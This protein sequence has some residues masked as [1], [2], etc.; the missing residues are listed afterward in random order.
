MVLLHAIGKRLWDLTFLAKSPDPLAT[1]VS[2]LRQRGRPQAPHWDCPQK[3][4]MSG[5]AG[6]ESYSGH[7]LWQL[8]PA[9][10]QPILEPKAS[11]LSR[12][13]RSQPLRHRIQNTEEWQAGTAAAVASLGGTG[14]AP[15][16]PAQA[17]M[18]LGKLVSNSD[19]FN[20]SL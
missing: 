15:G 18:S 12:A 1:S 4:R 3:F 5:L 16:G 2:L 19:W 9:S 7:S 20:F 14:M 6:G 8:P 13:A 11:P 10:T 17:W